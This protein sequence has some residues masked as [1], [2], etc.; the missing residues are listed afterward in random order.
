MV[1]SAFHMRWLAS[2][3]VVS[4]YHSPPYMLTEK[5]KFWFLGGMYLKN[6]NLGV[7]VSDR[8]LLHLAE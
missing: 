2:S 4:Q 3:E 8:Y 6:F 5:K 1:N 7:L